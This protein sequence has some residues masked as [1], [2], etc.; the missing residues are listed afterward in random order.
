MVDQ[1]SKADAH[2]GFTIELWNRFLH[3]ILKAQWLIPRPSS[4]K[5]STTFEI[6]YTMLRIENQFAANDPG[7][8]TRR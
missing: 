3:L 7:T 8:T 5:G 6:R 2:D 1:E 4:K